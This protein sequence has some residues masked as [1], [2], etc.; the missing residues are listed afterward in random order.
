MFRSEE[1]LA[2]TLS[3]HGKT[4]SVS[5]H[6]VRSSGHYRGDVILKQRDFGI[7]PVMVAGGTVK[8]KDEMKIDLDISAEVKSTKA[9][10]NR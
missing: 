9:E 5:F 10:N 2:G 8:V 4:R 1:L 3:L 7:T 6:I